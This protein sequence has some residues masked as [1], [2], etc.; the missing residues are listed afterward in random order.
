MANKYF[1]CYSNT[2]H[3]ID[4]ISYDVKEIHKFPP[5]LYCADFAVNFT[6]TASLNVLSIEI[7]MESDI[8][9]VLLYNRTYRSQLATSKT[10]KN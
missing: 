7:Y 4:F 9:L 3:E 10:M 5:Q 6:C 1:I 8:E 2:P